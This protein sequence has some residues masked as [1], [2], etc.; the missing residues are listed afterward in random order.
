[1]DAGPE[2]EVLTP[3]LRRQDLLG[4]AICDFEVREDRQNILHE[5]FEVHL[6]QS[7]GCS[8]T[9]APLGE[10]LVSRLSTD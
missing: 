4:L 10:P 1:M 9:T 2:Q 5:L 8:R 6:R 7:A 3:V